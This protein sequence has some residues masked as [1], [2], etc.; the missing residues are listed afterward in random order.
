MKIVHILELIVE[1][2]DEKAKSD[3]DKVAGVGTSEQLEGKAQQAASAIEG[4]I[5]QAKGKAKEDIGTTKSA[6][7]DATD[8][9]QETGENVTD[10]VKNFFQ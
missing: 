6:I 9:L 10:K 8:S 7:N 2:L 5:E 1:K 4:T 3:L